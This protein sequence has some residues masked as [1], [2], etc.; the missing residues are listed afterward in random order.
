M[1]EGS[2]PRSSPCARQRTLSCGRSASRGQGAVTFR[3]ICRRIFGINCRSLRH[4]VE[5]MEA[6]LDNH[7]MSGDDIDVD[8][9]A[10]MPGQFERHRQQVR[11]KPWKALAVVF[12]AG[13]VAIGAA[14]VLLSSMGHIAAMH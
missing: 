3:I 9:I 5:P 12:G 13:A 6:D 11:S 8:E 14:V 10:L 7:G 4:G 1:V 2:S